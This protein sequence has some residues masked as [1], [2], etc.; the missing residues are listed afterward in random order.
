MV[1][2][3]KFVNFRLNEN[4]LKP[5]PFTFETMHE[6]VYIHK[7]PFVDGNL[8]LFIIK[9]NKQCH[10]CFTVQHQSQFSV[11]LLIKSYM[12]HSSYYQKPTIMCQP[13]HVPPPP[14]QQSAC[15]AVKRGLNSQN[16]NSTEYPKVVKIVLL[17]SVC[18]RCGTAK[19]ALEFIKHRLRTP[20]KKD[21]T[22]Q[23]RMKDVASL[24]NADVIVFVNNTQ[25]NA[26]DQ[27][28]LQKAPPCTQ[29]DGTRSAI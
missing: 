8:I 27:P 15:S 13:S 9:H 29:R 26:A 10:S 18:I 2:S 17:T 4:Q 22:V 20:R 3:C 23:T 19:H 24:T 21:K 5:A 14:S 6:F 16:L 25:L 12:I 1:S 11:S 28:H 7:V